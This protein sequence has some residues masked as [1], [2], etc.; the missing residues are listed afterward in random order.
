[1]DPYLVRALFRASLRGVRTLRGPASPTLG[2]LLLQPPVFVE[3]CGLS[4]RPTGAIHDD[5]RKALFRWADAADAPGGAIS[6]EK[7]LGMTRRHFRKAVEPAKAGAV[8]DEAF[9]ALRAF[10]ELLAQSQR[11]SVSVTRG[12]VVKASSTFLGSRDGCNIFAYRIHM[13]NTSE[14]AVQLRS[15]HWLLTDGAGEREV[16]K[17][18]SP[19][20]VGQ[21]PKLLEHAEFEYASNVELTSSTGS[22]RGSFEFVDTDSGD[23]F[24]AVVA[25]FQ[26]ISPPKK[27]AKGDAAN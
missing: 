13:L 4:R 5:R 14:K 1:M 7:L 15:R 11:S 21:T 2:A 9:A 22:I 10:N 17:A 18:G 19:G 25:P 16:A 26:L 20:V 24:Q 8:L 23:V 6:H 27:G 3:E 12:V